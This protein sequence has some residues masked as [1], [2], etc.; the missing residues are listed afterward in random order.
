[1]NLAVGATGQL[2][3]EI[4][5]QLR[6]KN[7]LFKAFVRTSSNPVKVNSLKKM[8]AEIIKGDLQNFSS[9]QKACEG[10]GTIISTVSSVHSY[11]SKEN[12]IEE[13]DKKGQMMLIDAAKSLGVNHF[14]FISISGNM[15]IDFPLKNAKKEVEKHLMN[16][17]LSYTILR[18]T[19]FMEIWLSPSLGFDL[20][21]TSATIYGDGQNPIS[22]VSY[23]DVAKFA[24]ESVDNS[25][26]KNK[27]IEIGGPKAITP[28]QV[29]DKFEMFGGR[30]FNIKY[31][32]KETIELQME[33]A[34]DP[35]QKS[36]AGLMLC[37]SKGDKIQM[38]EIAGMFQIKLTSLDE[39][40][41]SVV[42]K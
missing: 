12:N 14:I 28:L 22:W 36:F 27:V 34:P 11:N 26:A 31:I 24:V 33:N 23:R 1:M 18:P 20:T 41:K 25:I 6:V 37:Y 38:D 19:Y 3:F 15:R 35:L 7:K 29:V 16:S 17:G 8:G 10:I 32:P 21:N 5:Q 40:I 39:Y 13:V 9:L 2:G 42:N 4:C 30:K